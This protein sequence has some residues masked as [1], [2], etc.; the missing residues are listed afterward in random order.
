M[1]GIFGNGQVGQHV[2]WALDEYGIENKIIGRSTPDDIY[3]YRKT[4]VQ[5]D[6]A[7]ANAQDIRRLVDGYEAVIYTSALRDISA[8]EKDRRLADRV[9]HLVPAVLSSAVPTIYISTDYVFGKLSPKYIR[10]ITGKIGEGEDPESEF[11]SFGASSIYGQ[12][13]RSGEISVLDRG[14]KV[15]RISSPFGRWKSPL[16]HSF[17]DNLTWQVGKSLSLPTDQIISPTYLPAAAGEIVGL[18]SLAKPAGVYHL[19][20]E[21][22]AS[23]YE[24]AKTVNDLLKLN[25]KISPRLSTQVDD[26]LR[27]TYSALQNNKLEKQPLWAEALRQHVKGYTNE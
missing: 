9:N 16:R 12:T 3:R 15:V 20:C 25:Q 24:I 21:G 17:V 8:C 19:A 18:L 4:E 14:G 23:F 10:P 26:M 5:F 2:A 22:A 7:A 1:I 27:P 13:K 11:F 6:M